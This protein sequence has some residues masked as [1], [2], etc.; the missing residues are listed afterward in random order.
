M[1]LTFSLNTPDLHISGK[2][3]PVDFSLENHTSED[4]W[5]LKWNT[6]LEGIKGK[7]FDVVCDDKVIQYEGRMYKRA[8][9]LKEDYVCIKSGDSITATVDLASAY[10]IP[11]C[12]KCKV[13]FKSMILDCTNLEQEV[14]RPSEKHQPLPIKGNSL[15]F[16]VL[17]ESI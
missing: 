1:G 2:P 8:E 10:N 17:P 5:I 15:I 14:P 7:I 4:L 9:P 11:A 12:K 16:P 13:V 6:P 3:L